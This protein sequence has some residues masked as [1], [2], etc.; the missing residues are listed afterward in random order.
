MSAEVLP[1][2]QMNGA[3]LPRLHGGPVRV[4]VPAFV[5]ARSV[6]WIT[7]ITVQPVPSRNYLQAVDYRILG[8]AL[9][10]LPS[11]C[12]ILTPGDGATVPAGPLQVRGYAIAEDCPRIARV[13]VSMDPGISWRP[14]D[15]AP[16]HGRWA[17]RQ[18]SVTVAAASGPLRVT[19]RAWDDANA[20]H[21]ESPAALRNPG[22]YGNNAW[23]RIELTVS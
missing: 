3:A 16:S 11:N 10:S 5:G 6:R 9:S 21:P 2:W 7:G 17:W 1:A 4:P 22:G 18:W 20:T 12:G 19:A 15:L 13:E 8:I 23:P 14:A